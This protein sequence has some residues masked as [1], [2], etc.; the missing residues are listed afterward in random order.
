MGG[1]RRVRRGGGLGEIGI[2]GMTLHDTLLSWIND[3]GLS[4]C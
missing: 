4:R 2:G 1:Y 3:G